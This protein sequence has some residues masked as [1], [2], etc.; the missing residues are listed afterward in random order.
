M[1]DQ[2]PP[3]RRTS[4]GRP[5]L[6][7]RKRREAICEALRSGVLSERDC[8]EMN[9]ID[10]MT[11]LRWMRQGESTPETNPE[12]TKYRNFRKAVLR[13]RRAG[14]NTLELIVRQAAVKDWR[15]ALEVLARKHPEEWGRK[16]EVG[17]KVDHAHA[18]A[19]VVTIS[20][21]AARQQLADKLRELGA[22][23]EVLAPSR[24]PGGASLRALIA[25]PS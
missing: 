7:T 24:S 15:A 22:S 23:P 6:C 17:G 11:Y 10:Y 18:H 12:W 1:S 13:A 21:D 20:P 14:K 25:K 2:P 9:G 8:A 19:H 3:P 4:P 5:S 16:L